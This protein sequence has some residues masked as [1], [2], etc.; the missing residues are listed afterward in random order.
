MK[1]L[2]KDNVGIEIGDAPSGYQHEDGLIFDKTHPSWIIQGDF[3]R[4]SKDILKRYPDTKKILDIGSGAGNLR[5]S[6]KEHNPGLTV[7]TLDGNKETINSPLIDKET[8][9]LLRTDVDYTLVDN[10]E[11]IKFDV[12]CSFEHFEHI[13]VETFDTFINNLKK[14]SH[15]DTILIASAA[16]WK[17]P[18]SDVH[19]NVKT[20]EQWESD[21]SNKYGMT[22]MVSPI[23]N[24]INWGCRFKSTN[25][26]HYK[27]NGL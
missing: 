15:K 24:N 6:F 19:C 10:D 3:E 16:T 22:K 8:H 20:I 18:N 5:F 27:I 2:N 13:S 17:Y 23:L 7:V 21:M 11:I 25:E 14:H 9:F 26:L 4:L 1:Q 12:I